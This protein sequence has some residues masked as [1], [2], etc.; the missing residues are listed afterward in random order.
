[1]KAAN[2]L[3]P[4]SLV[5]SCFAQAVPEGIAPDEPSPPGCQKTYDGNF[6]IGTMLVPFKKFRRAE[7][8]KQTSEGLLIVT[9]EDGILHDSLA[10]TGA[11]V[12]N[13][14]F[15]FDGPPQAG[16]IYT[17]GFSVCKNNSLA[18]GGSTVFWRCQSGE[19]YNIYDRNIAVQCEPANIVINP[20]QDSSSSSSL[21]PS[22]TPRSSLASMSGGVSS[23]ASA[24]ASVSN[25]RNGT[26]TLSP[27]SAS[28]SGGVSAGITRVPAATG[29]QAST[30]ASAASSGGAVPTR[31]PRRDT[32]GAVIGILGAALIL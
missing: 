27:S 6:T 32:F 3:L 22:A 7:A 23:E 24:T 25:P 17:G 11:I 19:F 16:S 29:A 5:A 20:N 18:L 10:R 2:I 26:V 4:L 8:L 12:A 15:Q 1:M 21:A 28:G 14:Q 13:Y 30:T 9:L 31:V